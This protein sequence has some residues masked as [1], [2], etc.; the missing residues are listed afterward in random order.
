M[1]EFM[2]AMLR[3]NHITYRL[4]ENMGILFFNMRRTA[5]IY[6]DR[7]ESGVLTSL[8]TSSPFSDAN[9][10]ELSV[11]KQYNSY[12][13]SSSASEQS[14]NLEEDERLSFLVRNEFEKTL[15]M[16][17]QR[18]HQ[19]HKDPNQFN[20]A[21]KAASDEKCKILELRKKVSIHELD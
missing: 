2:F 20:W 7:D 18:A 5:G 3:K 14:S 10:D 4:N 11:N 21:S 17:R 15:D 19:L 13:T 16:M 8:L 6:S 1:N 12:A 9:T